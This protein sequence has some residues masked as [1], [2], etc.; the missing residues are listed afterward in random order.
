MNLLKAAENEFAG[1]EL[2]ALREYCTQLGIEVHPNNNAETLRKKLT[3]ALGEYREVAEGAHVSPDTKSKPP[4]VPPAQALM[5]LNLRPSGLWGGRRRVIQ[6]HRSMSHD[7]TVRPQFFAW[8]MLHC[9]IPFG[10]QCE[11][12]YPIWNILQ[13]T[14]GKKLLRKRRVDEDGRIYYKNDWISTER[15]MY[16]DLGDDPTTIKLPVD[17][18]NRLQMLYKLTD[19]FSNFSDRQYRDMCHR[20]HIPNNAEWDTNDLSVAV[21]GR[22]GLGEGVVDLSMAEAL[23]G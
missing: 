5:R 8:R 1:A 10:V 3:A 7:N 4:E 6:L 22:L 21:L 20:L 13:D 11:I 9:Y 18:I 17:E 16:S 19:E 23:A 15:F 2:A 14:R 12:P